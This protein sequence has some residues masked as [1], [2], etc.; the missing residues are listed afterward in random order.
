ML[1]Y[2][3]IKNEEIRKDNNYLKNFKKAILVFR[4]LKKKKC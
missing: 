2:D 3:P 1:L 4:I